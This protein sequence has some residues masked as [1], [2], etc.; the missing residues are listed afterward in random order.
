[1]QQPKRNFD[2][3]KLITDKQIDCQAA[4]L[5][6]DEQSSFVSVRIYGQ[7]KCFVPKSTIQEQLDKIKNLSSKELAKNKIFKFLS[8]YNKGNQKQDELSHDYYG[9]FKVQQHQFIL[10]LE[11]AQRE[12]SLTID[13]FY[14]ING[15]IY[16][17]NHDILILQAHHVYQMQKP[18]LQLLQAASEINQN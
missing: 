7:F 17:T 5:I 8:E 13:D 18:T 6:Q 12:A 16:K 4:D 15:R 14:F 1:M 2:L 11:N 9:Y 10:N 3:Y